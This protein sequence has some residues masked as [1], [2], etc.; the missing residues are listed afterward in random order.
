MENLLCQ[1]AR[2]DGLSLGEAS[3]ANGISFADLAKTAGAA[4]IGTAIAT[5]AVEGGKRL[6]FG[7]KA[8]GDEKEKVVRVIGEESTEVFT[9]SQAQR[10]IDDLKAGIEDLEKKEKEAAEKKKEEEKSESESETSEA[11]EGKK[12][13]KDK[14]A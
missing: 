6:I 7:K 3:E 2:E 11:E 4:A 12:K 10:K 5:L 13:K 9:K 8:Q 1:N 14:A